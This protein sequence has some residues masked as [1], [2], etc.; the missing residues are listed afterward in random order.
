MVGEMVE[1][2]V[3]GEQG[4]GAY[5]ATVNVSKLASGI[6]FYRLEAGTFV[7]TKKLAVVK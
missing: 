5:S 7:E 1:D 2:F 3:N 4:P 6:Y